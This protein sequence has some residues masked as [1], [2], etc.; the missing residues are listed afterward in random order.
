MKNDKQQKIIHKIFNIEN[1]NASIKDLLEKTNTFEDK[2]KVDIKQEK[3]NYSYL[4]NNNFDKKL[5]TSNILLKKFIRITEYINKLI[6]SKK[7]IKMKKIIGKANHISFKITKLCL[8]IIKNNIN[9]RNNL[10]NEKFFRILIIITYMEIMPI[11]NLILIINIFLHTSINIIISEN[12]IIDNFSS[13]NNSPLYFI[14]DLFEAL[15]NIPRE[16]INKDI[17]IQ[18]IDELIS[19]LDNNLFSSHYYLELNKLQIWF[20]LLGNKIMN[21]DVN[22][23]NNSIYPKIILF[24]VKIYKYNFQNSFY[25]QNIYEKSAI[26]FD[27][28]INSLDF[29]LALFKE[30]EKKRA[31]PEFQIKNG[32][33]IYNNIPL[34][35]KNVK[36]K[37]NSYSLIFSFKLTKIENNKENII[38][39]NLE[40]NDHKNI[41]KIIINKNDHILKIFD[42]KNNEWNTGIIIESNKDYLICLS[43]EYKSFVKEIKEINLFINDK[44]NLFNFYTSKTIGYPDFDQNLTLDLGKSNFEGIFGE[45]I[46]INKLIKKENINHLFNLKENYADIICSINYNNSLLFRNKKYVKN[47]KDLSFFNNLKYNCVLKILTYEFHSLLKDS[48]SVTIKPYGELKYSNKITNNQLKIRI[49]S[50]NYSIF[51]FP[52][53]HGIEYLIFQLHKIIS[54]SEND[55]LLNFYLYKTLFFVLEYIKLASSFYIFPQKD[56]NKFKQEKKY[57]VFVLSLIILLNTKQ[58]NIQLDEK[59]R[60]LLLQFSQ[61]YREKKAILSLQMNISL[62]LSE[63]LYK[64]SDIKNYN[65]LFDEMILNNNIQEKSIINKEILYKF[66][67]LDDILKSSDIKHKKYMKVIWSF[68]MFKKNIKKRKKDINI[69]N[70]MKIFMRYFIKIKNPKK[71]Y[72]YLKMIYFKID[73]FKTYFEEFEEFKNYIFSND[74]KIINN[75]YK[76]C[77]YNQILC[78]LIKDILIKDKFVK[79]ENLIEQLNNMKNPDYIYIRYIFI[80]HFNIDNKPKFSF[81]KSSLNYENEM[82]L[83]KHFIQNK[84]FNFFSLFDLNSFIDKLNL[85]INYFYFLYEQFLKKE[86]KKLE[87]LLKKSIKLILDFLDAI[88]N[89]EEFKKNKSLNNLSDDCII[90]NKRNKSIKDNKNTNISN[91]KNENYTLI[92]NFINE[93]LSSSEVK[94]LFILYFKVYKESELKEFEIIDNSISNTIDKIYNPFYLYIILP[95]I[96]L[97][98]N[99]HKSKYYKNELLKIIINNIINK[100]SYNYVKGNINKTLILNSIITLIRINHIVTEN[101]IVITQDLEKSFIKYLE[102]LLKN[103]FLYSKIIF[104][105]NLIEDDIT[106]RKEENSPKKPN[107]HKSSYNNLKESKNNKFLSEIILDIIFHLIKIRKNHE[108]ISLLYNYLKINDNSSIFFKVDE[109]FCL[110]KNNNNNNYQNN[111][112]DLLNSSKIVTA[113]CFGINMNNI[114]FCLY[115]LI[116]FIYKQESFSAIKENEKESKDSKENELTILTNKILEILFNDCINVFKLYSKKFKKI[117][118]NKDSNDFKFKT[119]EFLFDHFSSKYKDNKFNFSQGESIYSYF[120]PILEKQKTLSTNKHKLSIFITRRSQSNLNETNFFSFS[121]SRFRKETYFP[122]EQS[123]RLEDIVKEENIES[124][125]TNKLYLERPRSLSQ[126]IKSNTNKVKKTNEKK[127]NDKKNITKTASDDGNEYPNNIIIEEEIPQNEKINYDDIIPSS[128]QVLKDFKNNIDKPELNYTMDNNSSSEEESESGVDSLNCNSEYKCNNPLKNIIEEKSIAQKKSNFYLNKKSCFSS[129]NLQNDL[130]SSEKLLFSQDNETIQKE[131]NIV[132]RDNRNFRKTTQFFP[133]HSEKVNNTI[134]IEGANHIEDEEKGHQFLNDKLKEIDTPT[135]YFK[136]CFEKNEPKWLTIVFIPKRMIFKIFG[137]S[138]KNYIFNNRRFDKLKKAF[139]IKYKNIELEK[140]IPEEAYYCLNYPSKLKNFTCNDYYKPFLK[141]MLNFFDN[142]YFQKAHSYIKNEIIKND[143]NEIDKFTEIKYEKLILRFKEKKKSEQ[144]LKVKIRCENISNKGSIFG[145]IYFGNSLM[146][147]KDESNK[148]ERLLKN[149]AE[150]RKLFY[151][152]SSD[153][154]DRLKN[155]NKYILIY[156]SDIKEIILRKF[157][158]TEI[159][160]EIFMK[161]GR[162]YFFNFFS[163]KNRKEFYEIF[164]MKINYINATL[165]NEEQKEKGTSISYIYNHNYVDISIINE[166][167]I[168]FEK[169]NLSLKYTKNEITNFQYLLLVNKFSS[170]SYND[171][172]QYLIFPL[173]YMD[174]NKKKLRDLSKA[175]C[176]NKDD[177]DEEKIDKF[178]SND[179]AIGY[180]FNI[181]YSTMAYVLYYLMRIIPFT[182]SQIKLQSGHFDVASRMFTSL[183]NLLFVLRVSDENRELIPELFYSYESFLNLNYNS[184]G[185]SNKKQVNHFNTNQNIGIIEF[186]IDLRKLLEKTE[187]SPWINNIFG[188]NQLNVDNNSLNKFPDYSYEQYNNFNKEK[189]ELYSLIGDDELEPNKKK[190]INDKIKNIKQRIQMI[191]LGLTPSQLFK[192]PHPLKE[193]NAKKENNPITIIE[194]NNNNKNKK[195]KFTTRKKSNTYHINIH[196]IDFIKKNSLKDLIFIVDNN[197][198]SKIAFFYENEIK[199]FNFISDNEKDHPHIKIHLDEELNIIKMKPYKNSLIELYNNFFL[200]CRLVNKTLLLFSETNKI[201]IEW[202]CIITAIEFYS[203]NEIEQNSNNK[204]HLNKIIIGDEE[205]NLSLLDIETEY[206][207]KKKELKINSLNN[208]HKRYKIFYSYI[209]GIIYEKRLNII[210][211]F[212][213]NG[214]ISINNGFSFEILNLIEIDYNPSILDIKLSKYDLLYIYTN[215]CNNKQYDIYCYTLNGIKLSTINDTKEYINYFIDE[216]G[217]NIIYKDGTIN[218]YNSATLKEIE[219]NWDK[220]DLKDINNKGQIIFCM[221]YYNSKNIYFIFEKDSKNFRINK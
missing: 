105:I 18:L 61:I 101:Y 132:N 178:K 93:L 201:F 168:I 50:L 20:K 67:L 107:S 197:D 26:S 179:K 210:I 49:Y 158:F 144:E 12:Q 192:S 190:E 164:L 39:F 199:I 84:N 92:N 35:L 59:I 10:L 127:E 83:L 78:F 130:L 117:K 16:L 221:D 212:N 120:I 118:S 23:K 215:K 19:I 90:Q 140:S 216:Y 180:H 27:Y 115:F 98:N 172:N 191:S 162:S 13:F 17:H 176:L 24:L 43:Q 81:I 142:D 146:I 47:D 208:I 156:F 68:I 206:N 66:L 128:E 31:N 14:N 5:S 205:G 53:Q 126:N 200:L 177:I 25:F 169:M 151:L 3:I 91:K 161:D 94:S 124:K 15:I 95:Q 96:Q 138:F 44:A 11:K 112:I 37:I 41:M 211:S 218:Q 149:L 46:I 123:I 174:I 51:N 108:L 175:I 182:Y 152:L 30:E 111:I 171:C 85:I 188:Y 219:K 62:L 116:F 56:K 134:I 170:R 70:N 141:P 155:T 48:K 7:D 87:L 77:Q 29:L 33:Y 76:Y 154:I 125:N 209:K 213:N 186:I 204:I 181:H 52:Y 163:L 193:K 160:Y 34:S 220:E 133:I 22:E 97:N 54:M 36:F 55:E 113:Y 153:E 166:P 202:P 203:H 102:Y 207:E 143:I 217:L 72:H 109:Y 65:K 1:L 80:H 148:D 40:N 147:F 189:E 183:E 114:L 74:N 173:L 185:I 69:N 63:K 71:I 106:I 139:K 100:N 86:N 38:L 75:N 195:A 9:S 150:N 157:C 88:L 103:H 57:T 196:L 2:N 79:K 159:A 187:L 121:K 137:Y 21:L 42:G 145:F 110:E 89:T 165:K 167:K 129:I 198:K 28:F 122:T 104:D 184:F 82:D 60:D 45:L 136:N 64:S 8:Y 99:I 131:E 4:L 214:F 73:S 6:N 135:F 119:Y 194:N 58:R 32:F